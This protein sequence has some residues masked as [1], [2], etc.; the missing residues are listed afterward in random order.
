MSRTLSRGFWR[1]LRE[2]NINTG[3]LSAA[4]KS[5]GTPVSGNIRFIQIFAG[6]SGKEASNDSE[7]FNLTVRLRRFQL[8]LWIINS[9]TPSYVMSD[10]RINSKL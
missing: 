5:L 6:F 10:C 3:I 4:K 9:R 7:C 2:R 8:R 1:Q